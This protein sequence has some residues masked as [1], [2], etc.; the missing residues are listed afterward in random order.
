MQNVLWLKSMQLLAFFFT[1]SPT[2]CQRKLFKSVIAFCVRCSTWIKLIIARIVL[3]IKLFPS[4]FIQNPCAVHNFMYTHNYSMHSNTISVRFV[5]LNFVY[6]SFSQSL[7]PKYHH[8]LALRR[9]QRHRFIPFQ[10]NW[11]NCKVC[12]IFP[13]KLHF[14]SPTLNTNYFTRYKKISNSQHVGIM[15]LLNYLWFFRILC[16]IPK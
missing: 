10:V 2:T 16:V 9:H 4:D 7:Y 11:R 13:K 5:V 1:V 12:Y 14:A 8:W 3:R 15:N 6:F